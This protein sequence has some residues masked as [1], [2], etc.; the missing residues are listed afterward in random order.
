MNK[1]HRVAGPDLTDGRDCNVYLLD[2]GEIVL[3]DAG[4]G[5]RIETMIDNIRAAGV[6]PESIV[7]II[8]THCHVD[9]I[10]AARQWRERFGTRLIMHEAD[11]RIAE[12]GDNRLTAAFCFDLKFD[13][14]SID[15][16]ITGGEGVIRIGENTELPFLH[17]PGHTPGSISPYIRLNGRRYLFG[18]DI[19]APVMKEFD[20]D[21]EAWRNSVRRLLAL[22]ADVLC[23]G[24]SPEQYQP[25]ERVEAY[26]QYF[27]NLYA[28]NQS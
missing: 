18:Q 4:F 5:Q 23:D 6:E 9:H 22:R 15:E 24:H 17:T 2:V 1:V 12:A 11:A 8:L 26:L 19:A 3:I 20:C 27:M 14:L 7:A 13:P 16:K 25:A 28:A 10:E 21:E